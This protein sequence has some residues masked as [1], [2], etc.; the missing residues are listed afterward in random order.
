MALKMKETKG[1]YIQDPLLIVF[2][3]K[4]VKVCNA[5]NNIVGTYKIFFC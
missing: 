5:F 1:N 2:N 3:V 4:Y